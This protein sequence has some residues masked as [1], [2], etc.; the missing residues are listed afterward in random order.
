MEVSL[1]VKRVNQLL[2]SVERLVTGLCLPVEEFP[3]SQGVPVEKGSYLPYGKVP[4][5]HIRSELF[6]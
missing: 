6:F 4:F 3:D 1:R 5:P 2:D